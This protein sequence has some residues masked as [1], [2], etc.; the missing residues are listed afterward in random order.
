MKF[1]SRILLALITFLLLSF[2]MT[3]CYTKKQ[4]IRKFCHQDSARIELRIIDTVVVK[5]IKADTVFSIELD[6]I[7]LVQDRLE[8]RYRKIRDSIYLEGKC[9]ADTFIKE[10]PVNVSVPC[11]C[12]S[13]PEKPWYW[14]VF[15]W[16]VYVLAVIGAFVLLTHYFNKLISAK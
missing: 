8:I 11:N 9:K 15:D 5:E 3:G 14:K 1:I 16:L 6:S 7:I 2:L 13:A 10:I 12:P 4:A